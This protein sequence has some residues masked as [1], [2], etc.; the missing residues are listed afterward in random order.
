MRHMKFA[1]E[2]FMSEQ[3]EKIISKSKSAE[4]RPPEVLLS[5]QMP[6][7]VCGCIYHSKIKLLL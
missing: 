5:S 6:R 7:N 1:Y 4:L 2:I 3:T